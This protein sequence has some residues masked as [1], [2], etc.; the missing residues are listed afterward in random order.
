MP[1]SASSSV[2]PSDSDPIEHSHPP[3]NP[4]ITQLRRASA[5]EISTTPSVSPASPTRTTEGSQP[6]SA[7]D[8]ANPTRVQ[9]AHR[10][11]FD[12]VSL[13]RRVDNASRA[14][15]PL[16]PSSNS[17]GKMAATLGFTPS[18]YFGGFK[19]TPY[20]NEDAFASNF[21]SGRRPT[22]VTQTR[23][24]YLHPSQI[25][26]PDTSTANNDISSYFSSSLNVNS[27]N[28]NSTS[29]PGMESTIALPPM[30]T[31]EE[32]IQPHIFGK[33]EGID[34]S[35]PSV[36]G[37]PFVPKSPSSLRNNDRTMPAEPSFSSYADFSVGSLDFVHMS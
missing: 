5:P 10:R 24:L 21:A 23:E 19:N 1:N 18:D 33:Q 2:L 14:S 9:L 32:I 35:A 17:K 31:L 36:F 7:E 20:S 37:M 30:L 13:R 16:A 28:N 3:P 34:T 12:E 29:G 4:P 15:D 8:P 11:S 26:T 27:N 25:F 6:A 22:I